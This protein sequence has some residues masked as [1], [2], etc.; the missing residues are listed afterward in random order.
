MKPF[1]EIPYKDYVINLYYDGRSCNN[2]IFSKSNS[3]IVGYLPY[4]E[5]LINIVPGNIALNSE[6][7]EKLESDENY[8]C[9]T[10][11]LTQLDY[12]YGLSL[13][14]TDSKKFGIIYNSKDVLNII[15]NKK[16]KDTE[17]NWAK[18]IFEKE[19]HLLSDFVEGRVYGYEIKN[20]DNITI[21]SCWGYIGVN[22][23]EVVEE[24]ESLIDRVYSRDSS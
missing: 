10:V 18:N 14:R 3:G 4:C 24:A 6:T 7:I 8:V 17:Y 22:K 9:L 23:K 21:D 12:G 1:E 13:N 11:Y 15:N 5:N 2:P 20:K 16:D 19:I